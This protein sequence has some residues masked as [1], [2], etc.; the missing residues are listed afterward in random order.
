MKYAICSRNGQV[1]SVKVKAEDS[2]VAFFF[3]SD[4]NYTLLT[5]CYN[6]PDEAI[7][8]FSCAIPLPELTFKQVF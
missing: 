4:R 7:M 6:T 1:V 8:S 2:N 5:G 3:L